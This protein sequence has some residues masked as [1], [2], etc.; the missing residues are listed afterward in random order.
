MK[1]DRS[2]ELQAFCQRIG[3]RGLVP[4]WDVAGTLLPREPAA[5]CAA[6]LWRYGD[7]R[8]WLLEA[9]SLISAQ[10]AERRVLVLE[11]P[12]LPG[13][14]AITQSLYAGLQLIQPGE[15]SSG[16]RHTQSAVRLVIEGTGAHTTVDGERITMHPGD[17]IVTPS[18]TWHD[19]GNPG[20]NPVIWLDGLDIPMLRFFAAGFAERYP[21]AAQPV[22]RPEGDSVARFGNGLL[23]LDYRPERRG[24]PMIHYPY[25]RTRETLRRISRAQSFDP[26][27]GWKMQFA[28]PATGG[29]ALPTIA[30]F[31]QLLPKGF[32]GE[33]YRSTDST[34]FCVVQGKGGAIVG[35]ECFEFGPR[36]IFVVPSWHVHHFEAE[37]ETVLFSFSD[38][39]V[40]KALGFWREED[41]DH[42]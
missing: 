15:V 24:S 21:H 11:N 42:V 7:V 41:A 31:M 36:D 9:G 14:S 12:A 35:S 26:R 30:A 27:H 3:M 37:E 1:T 10:E 23:P 17:F 28:D 34:V 29:Y 13:H 33:G 22:A 25:A 8:P 20:Q 2:P 38:R 4:L 19:Q 40:Q 39:P 16:H 18:W 5:S 32:S 6:A